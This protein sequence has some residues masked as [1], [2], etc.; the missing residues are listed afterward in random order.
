MF[1]EI[2]LYNDIAGQDQEGG[3]DNG[4]KISDQN[5]LDS[6][7][8]GGDDVMVSP[9]CDLHVPCNN[10]LVIT[11]D[12]ANYDDDVPDEFKNAED[13]GHVSVMVAP[14]TTIKYSGINGPITSPKKDFSF[15]PKEKEVAHTIENPATDTP[16]EYMLWITTCIHRATPRI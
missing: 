7:N 13:V 6:S 5:S 16:S 2:S 15:N 10:P 1:R 12:S 11:E 14:E 3:K 9:S 8:L 4:V